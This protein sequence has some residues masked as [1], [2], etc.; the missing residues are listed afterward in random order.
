MTALSD[1][2]AWCYKNPGVWTVV[3]IGEAVHQDRAAAARAM[4]TF[5]QMEPKICQRIQSGVYMIRPPEFTPEPVTAPE[6]ELLPLVAGPSAPEPE[7]IEILPGDDEL[8][9]PFMIKIYDHFRGK[10]GE[11]WFRVKDEMGKRGIFRWVDD[12]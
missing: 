3:Q 1:V 12:E 6:P 5:S 9:P 11:Q 8:Y 4:L 10:R 2:M 7:F